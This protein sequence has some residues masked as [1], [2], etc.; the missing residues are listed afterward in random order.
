[1]YPGVA[2]RMLSFA[3]WQLRSDKREWEPS[4]SRDLAA[5]HFEPQAITFSPGETFARFGDVA[6]LVFAR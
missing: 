1:M 3:I 2:Q 4:R 5:A 6:V